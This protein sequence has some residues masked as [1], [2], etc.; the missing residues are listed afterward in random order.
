MV[1]TTVTGLSVDALS[2]RPSGAGLDHQ[3]P[4]LAL[5]VPQLSPKGRRVVGAT[6]E[7]I[8]LKIEPGLVYL[9]VAQHRREPPSCA[10]LLGN[11]GDSPVTF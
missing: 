4:L 7:A 1:S 9:P 8:L 10:V 11:A 3:C 5:A 2:K 6:L